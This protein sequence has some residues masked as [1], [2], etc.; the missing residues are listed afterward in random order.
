MT[1]KVQT[2][3]INDLQWAYRLSDHRWRAKRVI[4]DELMSRGITEADIEA[5]VPPK[6]D[7]TVPLPKPIVMS[8]PAY[9]RAMMWR[10]RAFNVI[11]F[12]AFALL[13][14]IPFEII[15][16]FTQRISNLSPEIQTAGLIGSVGVLLSILTTAL[17]GLIAYGT[18][19]HNIRILLLRPFG[20]RHLGAALRRVV[21]KRFGF[22]G[23]VLTLSD[24]NYRPSIILEGIARYADFAFIVL[25]PIFRRSPRG[26][27][28]KNE[29][30]FLN[31]A[32]MLHKRFLP[33]YR[34]F[35]VG[36]QA[37]NIKSRNEWWQLCID[38]MMHS[39][40]LIVMDVSH[41]GRGSEWEIAHLQR[42]GFLCYCIFIAQVDY[43]QAGIK[44]LSNVLEGRPMPPIF[45][46]QPTGSFL[47]PDELNAEIEK[48]LQC[49]L[50]ATS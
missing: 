45:L 8:L 42:R 41:V 27:R 9:L 13:L 18:R 3:D 19:A 31:L 10:R 4:F 20:Q 15:D 47:K 50:S 12:A 34:S 30:M 11:R 48:R 17:A 35:L 6:S 2:M 46:Y 5:W 7:L 22:F 21:L 28:V 38:L 37:G 1:L 23:N 16:R 36:D 26:G 14:F 33:N 24:R 32:R 25:G 29:R 49:I 40:E 39:S 44:A 43:E